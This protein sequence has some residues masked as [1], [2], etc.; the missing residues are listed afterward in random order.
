LV[1][2]PLQVPSVL[3]APSH[4]LALFTLASNSGLVIDVGYTESLALPVSFS[5]HFL[6]IPT[7]F[8]A[9]ILK[10]MLIQQNAP[11]FHSFDNCHVALYRQKACGIPSKIT[12]SGLMN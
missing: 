4:Q 10:P 12:G 8:P 11:E 6:K 3:F 2:F 1:F 9:H 7:L 5:I